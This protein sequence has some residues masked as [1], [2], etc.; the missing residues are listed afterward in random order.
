MTIKCKLPKTEPVNPSGYS[1]SAKKVSKFFRTIERL[2]GVVSNPQKLERAFMESYTSVLNNLPAPTN[3][4]AYKGVENWLAR[5][6]GIQSMVWDSISRNK[7]QAGDIQYLLLEKAKV[8]KNIL[9]DIATTKHIPT[10]RKMYSALQSR[11]SDIDESKLMELLHDH[12]IIGNFPKLNNIYPS[13]LVETQLMV[14]YNRHID[15]LKD[16]GIDAETIKQLDELA[17]EISGTFDDLR[18]A[19]GQFGLEVNQLSNGGYFPIQAFPEVKRILNATS[20]GFSGRMTRFNDAE[21][22]N[23]T[24]TSLVPLVLNPEE[25]GAALKVTDPQ[26]LMDFIMVPGT[27]SQR[28]SQLSEADIDKLYNSGILASMPGMTDELVQFIRETANLPIKGLGE[29]LILN[30]EKAVKKYTAELQKGVENSMMVKTAVDD[31][32][33]QGWVVAREQIPSG[34]A[35]DFVS[36]SDVPFL[37]DYGR[38]Y[39][40]VEAGKELTNLYMHRTVAEQLQSLFMMNT[41]FSVLGA[42]GAALQQWMRMTSQFNKGILAGSNLLGLG[43]FKRIFTQ[44]HISLH[45][46]VGSEGVFRY[47]GHLAEYT[48]AFLAKDI[49][50]I[51]DNVLPAFADGKKITRRDLFKEL[52]LR[53]LSDF[54]SGLG[55][56]VNFDDKTRIWDI[57]N[58]DTL[59][60]M[61]KYNLLYYRRFG[62]PFT[63]AKLTSALDIGK[64]M[65]SG[66][67]KDA[68]EKMARTN[69]HMDIA[70][71]WTAVDLLASNPKKAGK[72]QWDNLDDLLR[73]SDEYFGI[74]ENIGEV[75]RFASFLTPFASFAMTAPG[76]ALRHAI[77]NPGRYARMMQVYSLA[78]QANGSE[79]SEQEK[80]EWTKN[81]YVLHLG[82]DDKGNTWSISPGSVDFYLDSTMWLKEQ[83]ERLARG[84]LGAEIGTDK[85]I[86]ESKANRSIELQNYFKEVWER[87]TFSGTIDAI[88][89]TVPGTN[90]GFDPVNSQDALFG[91][92]MPEQVKAIITSTFPL[93]DRLD[94]D[95]S[96]L[97][98]QAERRDAKGFLIQQG[99]PGLFGSIPKDG[100]D[101][102]KLKPTLERNAIEWVLSNAA[103]LSLSTVDP[104]QNLIRNYGDISST[105]NSIGGEIKDIDEKLL[106]KSRAEDE[107]ARLWKQRKRLNELKGL[108]TVYTMEIRK[109]QRE[110]GYSDVEALKKLRSL[111]RNWLSTPNQ[112]LML[113]L[114][115]NPEDQ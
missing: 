1:E 31:G 95:F 96:V 47:A 85:E 62:S 86:L 10:I 49:T 21:M 82:K 115:T 93:L 87:F 76:S 26:E 106:D 101:F 53:R 107:R 5:N 83:G 18:F 105:L 55:E 20:E 57:A 39:F 38:E 65:F 41:D 42:T 43:Y 104:E 40:N 79:L 51:R 35:D 94:R 56:R 32:L 114:R 103:G 17:G 14:K 72:A 59:Q 113:Y 2:G 112:S 28:L 13:Q 80:A 33:A 75:G 100:K 52:Q 77:R 46:A 109:L 84:L 15:R 78:L 108:F 25:L 73:Y 50:K 48:R 60:R 45:A 4:N 111:Q 98:G 58:P 63:G 37:K 64:E 61:Y 91:I 36:V 12:I 30:P 89:G 29:A 27:L 69:T 19:A 110:K 34:M 44:N 70:A 3:L 7:T 24:R 97:G 81:T 54:A 90:K 8:A 66:V 68:F 9:T 67:F 71:R 23:K 92:G 6:L 16:L 11:L 22:L 102:T 88:T 99:E 74:N